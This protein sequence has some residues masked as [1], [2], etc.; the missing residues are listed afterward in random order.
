[1]IAIKNGKVVLPDGSVLEKGTVLVEGGKIKAVGEKVEIP[2][3][4]EVLDVSGK[5]VTPGLID[6]HTHISTFN[7]PNWHR[8]RNDGNEMSGPIQAHLRGLDAL[9]P[10]DFAIKEVRNAGFTTCYT[11]PG[12]GNIIGG[13]GV[14]FKLRGK[15][16]DE[17]IIP[18][19]EA[20]KMALGENAKTNYGPKDKSPMTRMGNAGVW[21]ETLANAKNY[22]DRL[23]AVGDDRTKIG[24][25]DFTLEA[26]VPVVRGEMRC[27]IHAHRA[28]DICTAV[29]VA[30]EFGL[31]YT[32][33][34][35]TEGY[36]IAEY[37]GKKEVRCVVGPLL[38][39]P[40]KME[41][42]NAIPENAQQLVEAGC[43]VCLTADTSSETKWLPRDI[44]V[45]MARGL[46]EADAFKGVTINPAKLLGI[47]DRV[48]SLEPG[49]DADVAIFDGYP[50]SNMTQCVLTMIDGEIYHNAL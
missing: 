41:L 18:G 29:R 12:S 9:N 24:K 2:S 19:T 21:R 25:Y 49:K 11:G 33:E 30:E 22:S 47:E 6:A 44:G 42:W 48:G 39:P 15:V 1:M 46:K 32:I 5:W 36:M 7:E 23:K 34:H 20:M 26:L 35:A 16:A 10:Q 31:D 38:M 50:F 3:D 37:L 13:T 43:L 27:R 14:A 28:D 45:C 40:A 8:T 4:A 17:M